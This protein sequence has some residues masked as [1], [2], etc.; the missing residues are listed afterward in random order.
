MI[1]RRRIRISHHHS[2]HAFN[3]PEYTPAKIWILRILLGN[4]TA[5]RRFFNEDEGYSEHSIV[6]FLDL[7]P[8]ELGDKVDLPPSRILRQMKETLARLQKGSCNDSCIARNIRMLAKH[9]MLSE[10]QQKIL[11]LAVTMEVCEPLSDCLNLAKVVQESRFH[12][13]L[14]LALNVPRL[15][16]REALS[17]DGALRKTGLIKL[18]IEFKERLSMEVMDGLR[19]AMLVEHAGEE[20][21]MQHFLVP[22]RSGSLERHNFP[23]LAKDLDIVTGLLDASLEQKT[24]GVNILLYGPP[25]TG[26]TELARLISREVDAR[27]FEVKT[28]DEDGDPTNENGRLMGYRLSQ[29]MLA[30]SK[31]AMILFDEVEDIFPARSFSFFGLESTSAKNKGWINKALEENPV[32]TIWI[33]NQIGHLDP[34]V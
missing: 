19:D 2:T 27:L 28:E 1:H 31:R 23:H 32:P 34:A 3:D 17:R 5:F 33:S 24:K 16:I 7:P 20:D 4:S 8:Y 15:S 30:R 6:E 10:V 22:G 12:A 11:E 21:L 25:G 14:G 18:E 9:L 26:K 29:Y 13:L